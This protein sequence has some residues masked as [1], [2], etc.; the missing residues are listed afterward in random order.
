MFESHG[1]H[2]AALAEPS[3][4]PRS[5]AI[6]FTHERH[7]DALLFIRRLINTDGIDPED[8]GTH[9]M[10]KAS[11]GRLAVFRD[12]NLTSTAEIVASGSHAT[13]DV[14]QG[15][16]GRTLIQVD[17]KQLAMKMRGE[18]GRGCQVK[19]PDGPVALKRF[20]LVLFTH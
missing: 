7:L 12:G 1:A 2:L 6:Y 18:A 14:G 17:F 5:L 19:D 3:K 13:P 11:Q 4:S 20:V 8:A 16:K 15:F 10:S 9:I